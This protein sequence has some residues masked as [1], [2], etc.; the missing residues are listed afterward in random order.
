M[1]GPEYKVK[2]KLKDHLR[3]QGAYWFMPVQ[4]G[5]G[6]VTLDFLACFV[7]EFH[8]YECKARGKKMTPRQELVARQ[9]K[10]AGGHVFVVTLDEDN[11]LN[12]QPFTGAHPKKD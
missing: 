4:T 8:A 9:I 2:E 6:G 3:K 5:Y 1:H 12:F 7:G 11:E 10:A